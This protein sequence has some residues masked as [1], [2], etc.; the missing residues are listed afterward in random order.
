MHFV[1]K[2]APT[3]KKKPEM[4]PLPSPAQLFSRNDLTD[5]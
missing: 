5:Y 3:S 1:I 4:L 2:M